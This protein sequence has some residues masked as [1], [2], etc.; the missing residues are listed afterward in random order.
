MNNEY[1]I[2]FLFVVGALRAVRVAVGVLVVVFVALSVIALVTADVF[3]GAMGFDGL[4]GEL[5]AGWELLSSLALTG[6]IIAATLAWARR[7]WRFI[8]AT[9]PP[10]LLDLIVDMHGADMLVGGGIYPLLAPYN[11]W[12]ARFA[13]LSISVVGDSIATYIVI[14]GWGD[15][16]EKVLRVIGFDDYVSDYKKMVSFSKSSRAAAVYHQATVQHR[17]V[18]CGKPAVESHNEQWY[19]REHSPRVSHL[20]WKAS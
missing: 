13:I 16:G 10:Y 6:A 18:E 12:L 14:S 1:P 5:G 9:I 11:V 19:C 2:L 7:D 20:F 8:L 17:C 4:Y 3:A 15:I